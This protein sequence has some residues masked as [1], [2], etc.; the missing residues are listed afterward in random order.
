MKLLTSIDEIKAFDERFRKI[1]QGLPICTGSIFLLSSDVWHR[2]GI[3]ITDQNK[4]ELRV[5][6]EEARH[7]E[8]SKREGFPILEKLTRPKM[9]EWLEPRMARTIGEMVANIATNLASIRDQ[10]RICDIPSRDGITSSMIML[11][12]EAELK[13][14]L[15]FSL[16]DYSKDSVEAAAEN[17]RKKGARGEGASMLD[18]EFLDSQPDKCFDIIVSLSHFHHKTF[19]SEFL[20]KINRVLKDDGILIVGDRHS[21]M[22]DHPKNTYEL[23]ATI[24][25]ETQ[26]LRAF[27][28]LFGV[29]GI[30]GDK[31]C[32]LDPEECEA[33][34]QHREYWVQIANG[35]RSANM[36]KSVPRVSFLEAHDTS[37]A[38]QK[39][40]DD[41]GFITDPDRIR[42]AFPALVHYTKPKRLIRGRVHTS[43]FAV[44]MAAIKKP[45]GR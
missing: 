35:V 3:R 19:L 37:K 45:R 22:L 41:A 18:N 42:K 39:K 15:W 44:V 25:A 8:V 11:Q 29:D 4:D 10:I 38:R 1:T 31:N 16:T 21:A 9:R 23:L 26:T 30:R 20:Q 33:I 5:L 2:W 7:F 36:E 13:S 27:R 28:D 6:A 17:V 24:G 14:K 34:D 12:M 40:L 32:A 43:D